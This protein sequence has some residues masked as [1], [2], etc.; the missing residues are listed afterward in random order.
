LLKSAPVTVRTKPG[1]PG[2][3]DAGVRLVIES[4]ET[5]TAAL[6]EDAVPFA[7]R[8]VMVAVPGFERLA[9]ATSA[10]RVYGLS[11][12]VLSGTP[13]Q[14]ASLPDSKKLP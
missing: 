9:V 14:S 11:N 12:V 1:P 7:S 8:T 4:P 13:S 2:L 6:F 5:L 3:A 10:L